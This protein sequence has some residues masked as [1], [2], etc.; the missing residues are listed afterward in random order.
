MSGLIAAGMTA[1]S[2]EGQGTYFLGSKALTVGGNNLST[3][4]TGTISDGGA[5]GGTGGSLVVGTGTLTLAGTNTY[6]GSTAVNAGTLLLTG[7]ISSS[8]GVIV[9][10]GAMLAGTGTAPGILVNGGTLMP[11]LPNAV[12]TLNVRGNLVFTSAATYLININA[13]S[14]SL[15]SVTGIAALGG[16]TVQVVD[17]RTS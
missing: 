12:G 6:T 3:T 17:D 10:S 2:I 13:L 15:T 5:S 11:G 14:A 7:D 1:G 16:A 4:V 9:N 8:S